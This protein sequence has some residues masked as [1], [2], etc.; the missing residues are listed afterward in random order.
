ML[1][2]FLVFF[3]VRLILFHHHLLVVQHLTHHPVLHVH[4][5]AHRL[6]LVLHAY[7]KNKCVLRCC[8]GNGGPLNTRPR[9]NFPAGAATPAVATSLPA[10]LKTPFLLPGNARY[11]ARLAAASSLSFMRGGPRGNGPRRRPRRRQPFR[12]RGLSGFIGVQ[13]GQYLRNDGG[14]FEAGDDLH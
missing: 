10:P 11:P 3:L 12:L 5:G 7:R 8:P 13:M 2:I 14:V 1:L 9:G 6:H 4:P